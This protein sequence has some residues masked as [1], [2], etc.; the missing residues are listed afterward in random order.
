MEEVS[1]STSKTLGQDQTE[2]AGVDRANKFFG[3]IGAV[4][5]WYDL[6]L[7]GYLAVTFARVFFPEGAGAGVALAATL[8][9]FAVGFLMRPFGGFFFGWMGDRFGRKSALTLAITMMAIPMFGT[10]ILPGF[11]AWGWFAPIILIFFRMVQGFSSGG[12]YSGTLVF[13]S[14]G[15]KSTSRG[16][17]AAI[18]TAYAGLGILLA[19]L[20]ATL[21]QMFTTEAQLDAWGWRIPY[22]LG[23]LIV[24]VGIFMRLKMKETPRF[25]ALKESGQVSESPLR[26]ALHD[27]W[28]MILAIGLL[29]GYAGIAYF[30]S[31]TYLVSYLED[32]VGISADAAQLVG[33][34]CA[35]IY[36]V[37]AFFFGSLSDRVG[38]KPPM[39]AAAIALAVFALPAFM[40]INTG[41]LW[42]IYVA[43]MFLLIPVLAFNGGFYVAATEYLPTRQRNAG[44]GIGYNMGVA[45]LGSTA[46]F[47]AQVLVSITG[48]PTV[49]AWY[50]IIASV[51]I[52]PLILCL[53]ETAFKTLDDVTEP[54]S[55]ANTGSEGNEQDRPVT[56]QSGSNR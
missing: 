49:P 30:I 50:L 6:M 53:P 41:N 18:A 1:T 16:R 56:A 39:L 29:S 47:I 42:L 37:T 34:V 35:V 44:M 8:G 27:H 12:E 36:T 4:I 24:V 9:G 2:L 33:L 11:Q 26:E 40:L 46:P 7:Y 13:L 43:T 48:S 21:L 23:S 22:L 10:A 54:N 38:R 45:V 20:T 17:T 51:L 52:I 55:A 14:E 28:R 3:A 25:Q 32:T 5:E 31:L 15:A 19:S